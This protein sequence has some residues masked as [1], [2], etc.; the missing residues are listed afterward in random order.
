VRYSDYFIK[1]F[2]FR[3][4][5]EELYL[6][7]TESERHIETLENVYIYSALN[8]GTLVITIARSMLFFAMCLHISQNL[9]N[10]MFRKITRAP[11]KFFH[12]NPSGRILNRFSKDMGLIDEVL[13]QTMIDCFQVCNLVNNFYFLTEI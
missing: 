12:D 4:A 8:V 13:P 3:S 5:L 10:N 6:N 9:H 7:K 2:V 11:M 1:F